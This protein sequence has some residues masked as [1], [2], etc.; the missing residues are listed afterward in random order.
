[1]ATPAAPE[2]PEKIDAAV[3]KIAGCVILGVIM[4]ILDITV[5]NVALPTFQNEFADNGQALDYSTVAWTVTAYTLALATVIPLTGW[6][7]D[8]FGTKRLY[9][10]ALFL[11]TVGSVLCATA[12]SI[13]MLIG[14]RV[15]QGLGGGM[16]MPLGMTI[17]TH[18]AGPERMGRLMAI[19]GVP[20]L[21]GP[22]MGPILGGVLID[23]AS[24]HWVFLIN[25]PLGI[26]AM[27]YAW[28]ALP[29]DEPQP[30][31]SFDFLGMI[32]MSPGLALFLYGISSIPGE[33]TFT[34][35]KVLIP[36]L[37]GLALIVA[38]VFHT[39]RPEHPLLD[40][41]LFKN[42]NLTI[43][44]ITMFLFVGA[45]F[46][47][48]LLVPTYFQ[49]VRGESVT[50]SGL[51]V[52]AQGIGAMVT[53]PLAGALADK[54]PIGRF[55]P[56]GVLLITGGM[57]GLSRVDADT[58]Y[59]GFLIPVLFVMGL[60]MG[61]T[62]MPIMT[63]ALKTLR[64]KEI[65]RGSTLI[66][67]IQQVGSSMGVAIMSVI[68]TNHFKN[69]DAVSAGQ[70][71]QKATEQGDPAAAMKDPLVMKVMQSVGGSQEKFQA[72]VASDAASSFAST[73]LVATG[74]VAL[75]I[76]PALFLPRKPLAA[77]PAAEGGEGEQAPILMH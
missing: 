5:V 66:N 54:I 10:L 7:A 38:F 43:S 4:S 47:G 55:V 11:F 59:W 12:T 73:F 77:P 53:M 49:Q 72:L 32:L 67:I 50:N 41:R 21:L 8:R 26:I 69:S 1:M 62:M 60:G 65:A 58:S 14:F 51:I 20:M 37:V 35:S 18:A 64:G 70:I 45:F 9:I 76:I 25:L 57:F 42:R 28:R 52:A 22:I 40:L 39:F 29:N 13:E 33:G 19:L 48:L 23:H 56:I 68:L 36:M 6:A 75:C 34:S 30:S 16:L 74:L 63:S 24:W 15:L 71:I 17:L 2:Y 61:M 46:G 44:V 3:L 27:I 31:E